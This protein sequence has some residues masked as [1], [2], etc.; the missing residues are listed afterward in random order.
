MNITQRVEA[1]REKMSER[2]IEAYVIPTSDPHQSEYV[3][4]HYKTRQFISGFTGSAGTAV[5][6]MQDCGLWVDG[7]YFLQGAEEIQGTPFTLFKQGTSDETIIEFLKKRVSPFGKIGFD[8]RCMATTTYREFSKALGNR[9]LVTDVDYISD[10][11]SDR[12]PLPRKQAFYYS[13]AYCGQTVKDK[14]SILRYMMR[15]READYTFIGALEDICYLYNIRGGDIECT[16]VILSYTLISQKEAML[17]ID[18][19]KL[20]KEVV[21][22][23]REAGVDIYSYDAVASKLAEIEGQKVVYLDPSHTNIS[24]YQQIRDNVKI[25]TGI[26]LTS[27]MKAIKNETEIENTRKAFIKDGIALVKFFNWLETGVKTGSINEKTASDKLHRFRAEQED[28]IDD[29]FGAIIG[30]AENGAIVHYN[31]S[32]NPRPAVIGTKGLLLVDSGGHYL[33][34]TTDITRTYAMG[35]LTEEEKTDYTLVLKAHIAGMAAEFPEGTTGAHIHAIV[36]HPLLSHHKDFNHGTGHGVGHV[37][38]VHEGPQSFSARATSTVEIAPGMITSVE[39]GLYIAG[40]HGIRLE[41][42]TLC[43]ET[44]KNE[45]AQFLG[46]ECL[47]WVPLDT[48]PVAVEMLTDEELQWLNDYNRTCY[49]KLS[50]YLEGE[51]LKYLEARCRQIG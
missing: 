39:P 32:N 28:F 7:R 35:P 44:V 48:R 22:Q 9:M 33:Q 51:D 24:L 1:L 31:P 26:N 41:S 11:W 12:P 14:L 10:L 49:E 25:K 3:P 36:R 4:A 42:I 21:I 46:F 50:P 19:S 16:P 6:T 20:E 38:S 43:R 17:F 34:G 40:K 30:Y 15:D 47:T 23:L 5:V 37:L 8:G 18:A 29:S 27:L 13:E 2:G 45:F